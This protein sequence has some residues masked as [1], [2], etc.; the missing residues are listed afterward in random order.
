MQATYIQ[1]K[2]YGNARLFIEI[3]YWTLTRYYYYYATVMHKMLNYLSGHF[4]LNAACASTAKKM[5]ITETIKC[6]FICS[7]QSGTVIVHF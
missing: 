1:R 2:I 6:T 3:A 5:K 4:D 7:K